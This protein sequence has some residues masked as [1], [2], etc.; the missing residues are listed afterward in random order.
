MVLYLHF[1]AV[2]VT[3]ELRGCGLGRQIMTAA[4]GRAQ[5]LGIRCLHL[6]TN[7]KEQ[8]YSHLGYERGP[9]V[10]PLKKCT[11]KLDLQQASGRE[12]GGGGEDT[13]MHM[14]TG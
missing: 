4:E 11:A 3:P 2:V 10:S 5:G 14:M 12:G 9:V 13:A 1:T 7:D 8:F 6:F